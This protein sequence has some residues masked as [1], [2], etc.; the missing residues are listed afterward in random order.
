LNRF[1]LRH[2]QKPLTPA[3]RRA[4]ESHLRRLL[5]WQRDLAAWPKTG[6][7]PDAT[8]FVSLYAHGRLFGCFG[9]D[10]GR[11]PERIARAFLRA[12]HDP[13]S[14][15]LAAEARGSV[16]AELSYLIRPKK[17]RPD[18]PVVEQIEPG[19]HG[20][21]LWR[22]GAPPALLLPQV[23]RDGR[24]DAAGLVAALERKAGVPLA[25]HAIQRFEVET[26]VARLELQ[27]KSRPIPPL[28]LAARW[29][30]ARVARDGAIAFG[31][32]PRGRRDLPPGPMY[33]GRAAVLIQA[34]KLHGGHAAALARASRWLES[35]L[36]RGL[37]EDPVEHWPEH[38]AQLG[39]T[40]ALACFAGLDVSQAAAEFASRHVQDLALHPW[41]AAQLVAALGARAPVE[42][43]AACVADLDRS[44]F[45]AWTA[46]AARAVGDRAS[47]ARAEEVLIRSIRSAPPHRGGVSVASAP[48]TALTA[49]GVEALLDPKGKVKGRA[50]HAV[51]QAA[52]FLRRSQLLP[53]EIAAPLDPELSAGAFLATP[54]FDILRSDITAHAV[55]A[56][57]ALERGP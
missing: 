54:T 40:L 18:V 38:P 17:L 31:V 53:G 48:E 3:Q 46:I 33:Y 49:L 1:P 4:L 56:L 14:S 34:L 42:L 26:V 5:I 16:S 15:A 35:K 23:A 24:L 27:K 36:R 57:L 8:A 45:P 44:R 11:P 50:A 39:G 12:L 43:W 41:H 7:A 52:G 13:R 2:L 10:E 28:D 25:G 9:C 6:S 29:L 55:I 19:V 51:Q 47:F 32:D 37:A 21:A 20:L 22:D 30:A